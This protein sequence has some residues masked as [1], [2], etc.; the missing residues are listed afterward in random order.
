MADLLVALL[1][2]SLLS[3]I[4]DEIDVVRLVLFYS[5][6]LF[7]CVRVV[8]V[9]KRVAVRAREHRPENGHQGC[10]SCQYCTLV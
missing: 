1:G 8:R 5:V 2:L 9:H 10:V 3:Q 6:D 7:V 4:V